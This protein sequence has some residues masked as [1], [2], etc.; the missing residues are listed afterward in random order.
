MN[1]KKKKLNKRSVV[2]LILLV[3]SILMPV[4][5][6]VTHLLSGKGSAENL[7]FTAEPVTRLS[8]IWLHIHVLFGVIFIVACIFHIIF[9]WK[10]LK[11][12][13]F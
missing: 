2:A 6:L 10:T 11:N 4:S 8:H 1:T 9:N 5:A 7:L 3:S 12:Y 13:L